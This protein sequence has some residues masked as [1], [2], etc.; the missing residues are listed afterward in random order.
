M[1]PKVFELLKFYCIEIQLEMFSLLAGRLQGIPVAVKDNFCTNGIKTS[2][3]SR[4]LE[5]YVPPY[6]A[7]VVERLFDNGAVL[8]GKTNLD[9]F[10]MGWV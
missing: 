1:V 2:C 8:I 5:N 3:A 10:A 6:N 4:M 7:T 9:E